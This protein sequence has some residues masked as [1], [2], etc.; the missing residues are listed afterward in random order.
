MFLSLLLKILGSIKLIFSGFSINIK[1]P[2][3]TVNIKLIYASL[4]D[5]RQFV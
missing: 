2:Q 5:Y 1:Y 3:F 4:K